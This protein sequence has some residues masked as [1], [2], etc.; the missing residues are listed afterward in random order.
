MPTEP[1]VAPRLLHTL[2]LPVRWGDMDRLGHVNNAMYLRYFE[3][4]RI[5]WLAT[6]GIF[7]TGEGEGPLLL[8]ASVTW[9]RAVT[10]PCEIEVRL[11]AG[12]VGGTSFHLGSEIVN[13][14][15]AAE[16]FTEADFVM[17]WT[18]FGTT[19]PVRVPD[20]VRAVLGAA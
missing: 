16:R 6:M 9:L 2:R 4:S 17:V 8:K 14:H 11:F 7:L 10:Y 3:Q 18:D 19:R 20:R 15:D 12:R 1:A 5:E 13:A